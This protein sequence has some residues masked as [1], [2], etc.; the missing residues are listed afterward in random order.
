MNGQFPGNTIL[1]L[2]LA[3]TSCAMLT[4]TLLSLFNKQAYSFR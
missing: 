2:Q 3:A 4:P 1:I